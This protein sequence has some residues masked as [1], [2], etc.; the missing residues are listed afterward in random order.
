[1]EIFAKTEFNSHIMINIQFIN[2]VH[3]NWTIFVYTISKSPQSRMSRRVARFME[4][5]PN[6]FLPA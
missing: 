2:I 4:T 3:F 5:Q 6:K 1:M